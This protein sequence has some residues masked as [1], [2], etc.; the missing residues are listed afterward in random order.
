MSHRTNTLLGYFN[1][2]SLVLLLL[3]QMV[4]TKMRLI[5]MIAGKVTRGSKM[6]MPK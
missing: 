2:E 5:I 1:D 3:D 6:N 4:V